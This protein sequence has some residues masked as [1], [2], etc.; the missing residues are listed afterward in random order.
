MRAILVI[1]VALIGA[2]GSARSAD[3]LS[4]IDPDVLTG[5]LAY[6]F[7]PG[8]EITDELPAQFSTIRLPE[9]FHYI[10]TATSET[11]V[12]TAFRTELTPQDAESAMVGV[13]RPAGWQPMPRR[14]G[15]RRT[16]F[17][18]AR[19]S[20]P[21]G[22]RLCHS[23]GTV[24]SILAR[25]EDRGTFVNVFRNTAGR[26]DCNREPA[27]DGSIRWGFTAELM[28]DLE[29]PRGSKS[30]SMGGGGIIQSAGDDADTHARVTTTQA[31]EELLLHFSD[32]LIEQGWLADATWAGEVSQGSTWSLMRADLPPVVG[33]LQLVTHAKGDYFVSFAILA[34]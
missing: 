26:T 20:S 10:G 27:A 4:C 28:P 3:L 29:L 24:L 30:R 32:Q 12:S 14:R 8:G 15:D 13:L 9:A 19:E 33:N 31:P 1:V 2:V 22:A 5:L 25:N 11:Y 17:Q 6:G 23:D 21:G 18:P 34:R 7:R 16:G